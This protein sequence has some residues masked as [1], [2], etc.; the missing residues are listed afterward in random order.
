MTTVTIK[1]S[2]QQWKQNSF[3]NE[4][5]L[6]DYL[7]K[8]GEKKVILHALNFEEMPSQAQADY[9]KMKKAPESDIVDFRE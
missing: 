1:N 5:E 3:Q 2:H 9:L 4:D 6:L 8:E 7:L